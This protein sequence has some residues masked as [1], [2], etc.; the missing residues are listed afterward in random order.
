MVVGESGQMHGRRS[1]IACIRCRHHRVK[2]NLATPKCA[3]CQTMGT[4]CEILHPLS[5]KAIPRDYVEQLERYAYNMEKELSIIG[6]IGPVSSDESDFSLWGRSSGM[7]IGHDICS[8]LHA[9]L[10][11][12]EPRLSYPSHRKHHALQA[13]ATSLPTLPPKYEVEEAIIGFYDIAYPYFPLMSHEELIGKH[14][15]TVYGV[16]GPLLT[17]RYPKL[18]SRLRRTMSTDHTPQTKPPPAQAHFDDAKRP[19]CSAMF[20]LLEVMAIAHA[21][22]FKHPQKCEKYH[23]YALSYFYEVFNT[24]DLYHALIALLFEAFYSLCRPIFPGAWQLNSI[25]T[26]M[27]IEQG[28]HRKDGM[29]VG[30]KRQVVESDR[31]RALWCSYIFDKH[32]SSVLGRPSLMYGLGVDAAFLNIDYSASRLSYNCNVLHLLEILSIQD[33]IKVSLYDRAGIHKLATHVAENAR[34]QWIK[35][36]R[37]WDHSYS[38]SDSASHSN[39]SRYTMVYYYNSVLLVAGLSLDLPYTEDL[40]ILEILSASQ[41]II[42]VYLSLYARERLMITWTGVSHLIYAASAGVA[43]LWRM[44]WNG[45][46]VNEDVQTWN[47]LLNQYSELVTNLKKTIPE[48]CDIEKLIEWP[49][50]LFSRLSHDLSEKSYLNVDFEKG[51]SQLV[52]P[53]KEEDLLMDLFQ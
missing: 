9:K 19:V 16:P 49:K 17:S 20:F 42:E 12:G 28:L 34:A 18:A 53:P 32:V 51:N 50:Q 8:R 39:Y 13:G 25:I 27:C 44:F 37:E 23:Q 52:S 1:K 3:N 21:V 15:L 26:N 31:R 43:T 7:R 10:F 48:V 2:C 5:G 29:S 45:S 47:T 41:G 14:Y 38:I 30:V 6:R 35:K 24:S 4:N 46:L 40:D 22:D 36:L 11:P 33:G